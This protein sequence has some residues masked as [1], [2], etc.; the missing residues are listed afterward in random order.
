MVV[1][2]G[3]EVDMDSIQDIVNRLESLQYDILFWKREEKD[4]KKIDKLA[5]Y[6]RWIEDT[7]D[8]IYD[9]RE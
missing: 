4:Q 5:D 9:L 6:D 1:S 3:N 2:F 8:M 7:I